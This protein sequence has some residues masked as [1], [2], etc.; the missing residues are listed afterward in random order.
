[1]DCTWL[2][3]AIDG[4]FIIVTVGL[5][6]IETDQDFFTLGYGHNVT[7]GSEL[8]RMSGIGAPSSITFNTTNIW[9]R[10]TTDW[11]MTWI[12]YYVGVQTSS[13]FGK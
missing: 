11:K 6:Y 5:I 9:M 4:E 10:F 12:G 7:S 13:Q 2:V 3:T 1:M 8:A